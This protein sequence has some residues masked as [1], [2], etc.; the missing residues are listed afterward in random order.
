M[1][2]EIKRETEKYPEKNKNTTYQNF[3]SIQQKQH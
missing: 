2:K 3:Y 1:R